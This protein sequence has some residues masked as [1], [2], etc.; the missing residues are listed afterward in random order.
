[1]ITIIVVDESISDLFSTTED[2]EVIDTEF[3]VVETRIN[4]ITESEIK[5]F[6]S[7]KQE[8]IDVNTQHS[9]MPQEFRPR[10]NNR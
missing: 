5:A 10:Y 9:H 2:T 4:K 3:E 1:M 7:V 6:R 8:V